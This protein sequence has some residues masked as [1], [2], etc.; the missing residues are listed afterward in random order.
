MRVSSTP[1]KTITTG[2]VAP[3]GSITTVFT[4]PHALGTTPTF[5]HVSP[6]N[7]LSTALFTTTW[8]ATNITVTYLT[9]LTGALSLGWMAVA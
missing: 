7:L 9:G 2:S 8:D 1:V 5:A 3:T 4:I 6:K